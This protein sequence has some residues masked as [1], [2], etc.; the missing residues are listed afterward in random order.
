[1]G[2]DGITLSPVCESSQ[3]EQIAKLVA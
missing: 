1:V 2:S 3:T